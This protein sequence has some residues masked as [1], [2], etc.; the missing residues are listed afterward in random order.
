M[1]E[2]Y[3]KDLDEFDKFLDETYDEEKFQEFIDSYIKSS[4]QDDRTIDRKQK[5][6]TLQ[7]SFNREFL[8]FWFKV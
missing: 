7:D 1:I 3:F 5:I 2:K 4:L 6:L 8:F